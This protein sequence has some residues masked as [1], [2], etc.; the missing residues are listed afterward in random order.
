MRSG[1][2]LG[3]GRLEREPANPISSIEPP[4]KMNFVLRIQA[5]VLFIIHID[6]ALLMRAMRRGVKSMAHGLAR[7]IFYKA[8][9]ISVMGRV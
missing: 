9:R 4:L 7:R 8:N 6:I 1:C 2:C 3:R 5:T